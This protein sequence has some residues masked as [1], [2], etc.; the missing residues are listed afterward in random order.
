MCPGRY[1]W[2]CLTLIGLMQLTPSA[3]GGI[4]DW[5]FHHNNRQTTFYTPAGTVPAGVDL[6]APPT[7]P[8]PAA[9]PV[10]AFMPAVGAAAGT[11]VSVGPATC[12][13]TV[14]QYMPETAYRT[15]WN[16][17][18]VT[19]YQTTT[20]IN[21]QTGLPVTCT[22]PCVTY[23][24]Q[25]QRVP[26]TT[27]RPVFSQ[28]PVASAPSYAAP[29]VAATTPLTGYTPTAVS[30]G[31]PTA[32]SCAASPA[33]AVGVGPLASPIPTTPY[34][35]P[36]YPGLVAPTAPGA[37]AVPAPLNTAPFGS[38]GFDATTTNPPG[39]TPWMPR[40]AATA[41]NG[42]SLQPG[43]S[44]INGGDSASGI[45]PRI[46]PEDAR[47]IQ[48]QGGPTPEPA[49]PNGAA[50]PPPSNSG[51]AYPSGSAAANSSAAAS[52]LGGADYRWNRA[53]TAE[54]SAGSRFE[55]A[56]PTGGSALAAVG[57]QPAGTSPPPSTA[58]TNAPA[59]SVGRTNNW[60]SPNTA[61]ADANDPLTSSEP[62]WRRPLSSSPP[63]SDSPAAPADDSLRFRI[64][65]LPDSSGDRTPAATPDSVP[66]LLDP[67]DLTA[68][69]QRTLGPISGASSPTA[70]VH[71]TSGVDAQPPAQ[72]DATPRRLGPPRLEVPAAARPALP[73]TAPEDAGWRGQ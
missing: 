39:A 58:V 6:G 7:T 61:A 71:W 47:R 10:A 65:P 23:S 53:L 42:S 73:N 15:V 28:V 27:F 30:Y 40:D 24:Y 38:N 50:S 12:E 29:A 48:S 14:V 37:V 51:A 45:P 31:G 33:G 43:A 26:Y 3:E 4:C 8:A 52:S 69:R 2:S 36:T 64:R 16:P 60:I 35:T 21:P 49:S 68:S 34:A 66:S 5:L 20:N 11:P 44:A 56:S 54:R 22:R 55:P 17:V 70:P 72:S 62:W 18:P 57:S 63:P 67:N 25:A 1:W 59:A 9:A 41:P 46:N 32:A 19:Q 13:Q